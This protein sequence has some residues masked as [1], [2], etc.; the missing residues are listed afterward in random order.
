MYDK[1]KNQLQKKQ[2]IRKVG[3]EWKTILREVKMMK[4]I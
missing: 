2:I 1:L 3:K 4:Y